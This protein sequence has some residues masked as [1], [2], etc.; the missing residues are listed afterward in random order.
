MLLAALG[1]GDHAL[2][3]RI[4]SA[5]LDGFPV[6]NGTN[7]HARMHNKL[8]SRV[9]GNQVYKG[10]IGTMEQK[11]ETTLYIGLGFRVEEFGLT[12][13]RD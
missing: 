6:R 7:G 4:A 9:S 13:Y 10:Y 3:W 11:M 2:S 1:C 12:S 5:I 8:K